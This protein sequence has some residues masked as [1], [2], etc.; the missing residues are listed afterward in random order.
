MDREWTCPRSCTIGLGQLEIQTDTSF[1]MLGVLNV[2]MAPVSLVKGPCGV[3][4]KRQGGK[5]KG[6][7]KF[8][9]VWSQ[10]PEAMQSIINL[11]AIRRTYNEE[12]GKE[13]MKRTCIGCLKVVCIINL[14]EPGSSYSNRLEDTQSIAIAFKAYKEYSWC[15]GLGVRHLPFGSSKGKPESHALKLQKQKEEEK[16]RCATRVQQVAIFRVFQIL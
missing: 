1:G 14:K 6:D 4:Q 12:D 10:E 16:F 5:A 3:R 9:L 7:F 11:G 15:L 2:Y 8:S 13:K